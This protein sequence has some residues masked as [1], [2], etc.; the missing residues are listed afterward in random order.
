MTRPS[1]RMVCWCF[2]M[3]LDVALLRLPRSSRP[4]H[5]SYHADDASLHGGRGR[6]ADERLG[7][8]LAKLGWIILPTKIALLLECRWHWQYHFSQWQFLKLSWNAYSFFR[9]SDSNKSSWKSKI[10]INISSWLFSRYVWGMFDADDWALTFEIKKSHHVLIDERFWHPY[11]QWPHQAHRSKTMSVYSNELLHPTKKLVFVIMWHTPRHDKWLWR[12]LFE[13]QT[14]KPRGLANIKHHLKDLPGREKTYGNSFCELY[15]SLLKAE[16][17][18]ISS[19]KPCGCIP[20][21]WTKKHHSSRPNKPWMI[22]F[23]VTIFS[24]S[25]PSDQKANISPMD[26][27][28]SK[29]IGGFPSSLLEMGPFPP[30]LW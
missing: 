22:F 24:G 19:P 16:K 4:S 11:T 26:D 28:P 9:C 25:I 23:Q 8:H 7:A 13:R 30:S 10:R 21:H 27:F 29:L 12:I 6:A 18:I 17:I 1:W 20:S 15:V 14:P 5:L 2:Q 3:D